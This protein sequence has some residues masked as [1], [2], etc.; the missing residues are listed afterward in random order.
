MESLKINLEHIQTDHE[1]IRKKLSGIEDLAT[2]LKTVG[3]IQPVVVKRVGE[4]Q[5]QLI[6]GHR[7]LAAA[8]MAGLS[9][10]SAIVISVEDAQAK[11]IQLVENV[12]RENLAAIEV[13]ESLHD[14]MRFEPDVQKLGQAIG[15]SDRWVKRHLAL[16]K[17]DTSLVQAMNKQRL[18]FAQAE[19]IV[20]L[21][22]A[23]SVSEAIKA[24]EKVHE[25]TMSKR[26]IRAQ[27]Q[28]LPAAE[29]S[30]RKTFSLNGQ[31]YALK[32]NIAYELLG[33]VGLESLLEGK[34]KEIEQ[35]LETAACPPVGGC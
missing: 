32:M 5:Y 8:H 18:S 6:A 2:S 30:W 24:A 34:M 4:Q 25:G 28:E 33:R 31:G 17:V 20:R 19:E 10:L 9:V 26:D 1:N 23:T 15:K 11:T 3:Q 21:S 35:I 22:R 12:Q 7:R 13:A 14:L 27:V 29:P 16:L